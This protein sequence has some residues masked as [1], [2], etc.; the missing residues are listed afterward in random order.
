MPNSD[1]SSVAQ[2]VGHTQDRLTLHVR[3]DNETAEKIKA[4]ARKAGMPASTYIRM[5]VL[6]AL[7][8]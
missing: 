2:R 4:E 6:R 1:N 5:H 3:F 8:S 7:E